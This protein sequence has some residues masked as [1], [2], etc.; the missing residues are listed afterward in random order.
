MKL[1]RLTTTDENALFSNTFNED[2][3]IE[4]NS[5]IALHSLTTQ[6]QTEQI[7]I[8]AQNDD[9]VYGITAPVSRLIHLAHNTYDKTNI[10]DFFNDFT[11]KLNS[12]LEFNESEIGRQFGVSTA[13]NKLIVQLQTGA[14]LNPNENYNNADFQKYLGTKNV[15]LI[16]PAI[17]ANATPLLHRLGGTDLSLDSFIYLKS[18]ICKGV[19]VFRARLF[20]NDAIPAP[21]PD[22][23]IE[24]GGFVI[25]YYN[26]PITEDT[27]IEP[28]NIVFGVRYVDTTQVYKMYKNGLET[29]STVSPII[30][31]N[32]P[33][34]PGVGKS[35]N[36]YISIESSQNE[37]RAM[38]YNVAGGRANGLLIDSFPF[39]HSTELYPFCSFVSSKTYISDIQF[40]TD[41]F[42][43]DDNNEKIK[44]FSYE[45]V[46]DETVQA[47]PSLKINKEVQV[48]LQIN[49]IDLTRL[50][51]FRSQRMPINGFN[52]T[53]QAG[54]AEFKAFKPL[55]FRDI[56]DTYL[57]EM[58]NLNINSYDS[59]K[60]QRMNLLS[61]IP[62]LDTIRE[63]LV[64][65]AVYPVFLS[66]N[67]PYR[68]NLREVRARILKEDLAPI[69]TIG[70]SQ[71]T[72]LIDN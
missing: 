10:D 65:D 37:L 43:N 28:A 11:Y 34:V 2:I 4:P 53:N 38:V 46:D 8:N 49:D 66:L 24:H 30:G 12:S 5:K 70:Y 56:A 48:F 45:T 25:G 3:I 42:Y 18:T 21:P 64:Y 13:E 72:I 69:N 32:P 1:I 31:T 61:V 58:L 67:N 71:I 40:V 44:T 17:P 55:S 23:P 9:I 68:I 52:K 59:I 15:E 27:V 20:K 51:G 50:L 33:T 54:I 29:A 19:S 63:R 36:D 26:R 22:P 6:I 35:N 39:D 7:V 60:Q 47:I 57:V 62:Q 16:K 14:I 41:P